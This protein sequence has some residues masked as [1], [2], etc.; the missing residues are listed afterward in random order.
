MKT[1]I[2]SLALGIV[3][4]GQSRL[5]APSGLRDR[6]IAI[7]RSIID[8]SSATSI[9]L[10]GRPP[11]QQRQRPPSAGGHRPTRSY[12]AKRTGSAVIP[13]LASATAALTPAAAETRAAGEREHG[14]RGD[15]NATEHD[16]HPA[17][18]RGRQD[19]TTE[20][21]SAGMTALVVKALSKNLRAPRSCP[22]AARSR[23]SQ[24][25]AGSRRDGPTFPG[26]CDMPAASS[27]GN[28][29]AASKKNAP[30]LPMIGSICSLT[31]RKSASMN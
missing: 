22:M 2:P 17:G 7:E 1:S 27:A 24:R 30:S 12:S 16:L 18:L 20:A 11:P 4:A 5:M 8:L 28:S 9:R 25:H 13:T 3:L 21:A 15:Y 23:R 10:R 19:T 6:S 29:E 31:D 26:R 14:S